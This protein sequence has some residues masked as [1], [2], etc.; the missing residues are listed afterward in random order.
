MTFIYVWFGVHFKEAILQ[1]SK[2]NFID[3]KFILALAFLGVMASVP[4]FIK[5]I[6]RKLNKMNDV[7]F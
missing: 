5:I 3:T 6:F 4:I 7:S 1:G 2:E